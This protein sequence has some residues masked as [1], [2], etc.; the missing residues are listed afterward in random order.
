LRPK[1]VSDP[2]KKQSGSNKIT[3]KLNECLKHRKTLLNQLIYFLENI[4]AIYKLS[5]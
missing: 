4:P 5:V 1:I 2:I 3:V